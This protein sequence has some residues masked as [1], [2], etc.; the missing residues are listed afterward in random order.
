MILK[1]V[2]GVGS[3]LIGAGIYI[4]YWAEFIFTVPL[5]LI[6]IY[7]WWYQPVDVNIDEREFKVTRL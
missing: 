1:L 6:L 2:L 5:P 7:L 4:K 3:F